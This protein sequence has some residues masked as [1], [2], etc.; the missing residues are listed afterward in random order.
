MGVIDLLA[1]RWLEFL[2]PALLQNTLFLALLLLKKSQ[3]KV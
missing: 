1:E 2:G 3:M